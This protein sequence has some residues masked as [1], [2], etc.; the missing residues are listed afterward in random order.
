MKE[1]H[2]QALI[3]GM[4]CAAFGLAPVAYA[5]QAATDQGSHHE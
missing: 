3:I 5:Q 1:N 2:M 4:I